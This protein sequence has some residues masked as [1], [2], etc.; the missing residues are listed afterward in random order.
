MKKEDKEQ[1]T[2]GVNVTFSDLSYSVPLKTA[3]DGTFQILNGLSGAF[4]PGR[5]TA[6]M[7][8]SGSGK[9]TLMDILAGRK[10]AGTIEGSV[11]MNGSKPGEYAEE[12]L[13]DIIG[14]VEQFDT[15]VCE[16]TVWQMLSYTA[17]LKLPS[18]TTSKEQ[19]DRVEEVIQML[20][21]ESC[22]N[23][24]IGNA[25][26]RGISGGQAKRVNI[27]LALITRPSVLYLDE[28]TSG[29]DSR[30]ANEV[31]ELLR[32][33]AKEGRT[34]V[35]TIHSP[36]G[37]AFTLFD[38]LYML[39]G[40]QTTFDGPTLDAQAYFEAQGNTRDLDCSL[41]EWL[42]DLTSEL[43]AQFS[44][45]VLD[46]ESRSESE[47][48]TTKK[49]NFSQLFAA[50]DAKKKADENRLAASA[51]KGT[52]HMDHSHKPPGGLRNL[53]TLL[54]YRMVAHYKDE[55]FI[56]TRFGDK[57]V[58]SLLIL[59]LYWGIGDNLDSKSIQSM[60]T[61]LFFICAICGYGAAAFVPSISLE[62]ALFYRELADG[63]YSPP[64]YYA[65]K[66]IE[67]GVMATFTSLLFTIIVFF[68]CAFQGSFFIFFVTYY[69]TTMTGIILAYAIAA[70]VPT[71]EAANAVLPTYVTIC[72]FFG[73]LIIV[74]DKIPVRKSRMCSVLLCS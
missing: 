54:R 68:G 5:M 40:G 6:L 35:C 19:Q 50:S 64:T 31:V 60:A 3:E 13:K 8:P 67:E 38:D 30:T 73:G 12:N 16:L 43:P 61:L 42:V 24:V 26:Q 44:S 62:R 49:K 33:L 28:P 27:G 7:G 55:T 57:I 52:P 4:L 51:Q 2:G 22:R 23:T 59:S 20:D 9:T 25:L 63:C 14:Y 36:T 15:L 71:M 10:N 18:T 46:I 47:T 65:A 66:F 58:F 69:L 1:K 34:V 21:L 48:V 37:H 56:G 41:P 74:F 17:E 70:I 39:H 72:M 29:L 53:A 32:N 11:L 45:S